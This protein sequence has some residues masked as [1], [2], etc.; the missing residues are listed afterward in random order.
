VLEQQGEAGLV[1]RKVDGMVSRR[2]TGVL[3]AALV[4]LV[5]AHNRC[6]FPPAEYFPAESLRP[7]P[8]V[9]A[10]GDAIED[11][12]AE[13]TN[14]AYPFMTQVPWNSAEF[15]MNPG[16]ADPVSWAKA[17]GTIIDM[18]A[19]MDSELVKAGCHAHHVAIESVS[20]NGG[21]KP[22]CTPAELTAINAA[23]GRMIASVPESKTMAVYDAVSK[24]VDP[25]V[26]AYLMSKVE[27][28]K[29]K[30]A[31]EA[32]IKFTEVVKANSI[33]PSTPA[34]T[35]SGGAAAAIEGA[36][37]KLSS[38]AYPFMQGVDWKDDVYTKPVPNMPAQRTMRA[39]DKMIVLGTEM[40]GA[41]LQ[42]AAKAHVKAIEGMDAKGVLTQKDFEAVLA[43]LGKAISSVPSASVM[44]VFYEMNNLV[45]NS[46]MANYLYSKQDP[47]KA[48]SAYSALIEFKDTVAE[49]QPKSE[50]SQD[51]YAVYGLLL[52]FGA[53]ALI[54]AK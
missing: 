16:T 15:L 38:A 7:R 13:L 17:I 5:L 40:D 3:A 4:V 10:K 45:G 52:A 28:K 41:A 9:K 1:Y 44:N 43:G 33:T 51:N 31:Y 14:E 2:K 21:M 18:G 37:G 47:T 54:L 22:T 11:A 53:F 36:A 32:L 29:A 25:K 34:T 35:V 50:E 30:T 24:L 12:A 20:V 27:E 49:H 26:P 39:I 46:G 6:F 19:S 42:D 48:L 8:V 23:I